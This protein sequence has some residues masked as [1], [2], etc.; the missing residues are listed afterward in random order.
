MR[1]ACQHQGACQRSASLASTCCLLLCQVLR[2]RERAC[3]RALRLACQ[4][5]HPRFIL[6]GMAGAWLSSRPAPW[7]SCALAW[8]TPVCWV[9]AFPMHTCPLTCKA[10]LLEFGHA[11]SVDGVPACLGRMGSQP[12]LAQHAGLVTS[13]ARTQVIAEIC[14]LTIP[15]ARLQQ[16]MHALLQALCLQGTGPA[17]MRP[18]GEAAPDHLPAPQGLS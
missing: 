6:C 11:A 3:T 17:G 4:R 1:L 16:S 7:C 13:H 5:L 8:R 9:W 2:S 18:D 12:Q 10:C 14:P 15:A